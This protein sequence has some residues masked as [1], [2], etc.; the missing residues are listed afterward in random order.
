MLDEAIQSLSEIEK[1][2]LHSGRGCHYRWPEWIERTKRQ[3]LHVQCT[4]ERLL[5]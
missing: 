5:T 4:K 3:G 1:S 2:I